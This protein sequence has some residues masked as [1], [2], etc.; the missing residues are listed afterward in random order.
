[1]LFV[2]CRKHGTPVFL[3]CELFFGCTVAGPHICLVTESVPLIGHT[4]THTHTHT[5]MQVYFLVMQQELEMM[6]DFVRGG[7]VKD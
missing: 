3:S 1:M 4:H 7:K 6:R 2:S 5:Q